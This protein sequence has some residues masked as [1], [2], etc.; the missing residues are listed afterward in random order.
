MKRLVQRKR[1]KEMA[2]Q[3]K[4][5][6]VGNV[7]IINT[8]YNASLVADIKTLPGRRY[9]AELKAW[10]VP[11]QHE[12]QVREIVRKYFQ[13]EGEESSVKY[14]IVRVIVTAKASSK[15]TYLG[16]VTVDGHDIINMMYGSVRYNDD[17]FEVLQEKGGFT[18]GDANHAWE[19][20]YDLT[21]KTRKGAIFQTT[22]H[23]DYWGNFE[24]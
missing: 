14:S 15:R 11:V 23:A 20:E 1:V 16:G 18:R 8:P 19:V 4:L 7:V 9:N 21:L 22:G 6:K 5:T 17:T 13:I 24:F 2:N 12:E 10:S 3:A